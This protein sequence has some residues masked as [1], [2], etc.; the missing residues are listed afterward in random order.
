MFIFYR[1]KG[2]IIIMPY[3]GKKWLIDVLY[4]EQM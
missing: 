4:G 3:F 2:N 1:G